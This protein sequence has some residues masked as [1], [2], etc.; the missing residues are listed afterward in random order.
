MFSSDKH[1]VCPDEFQDSQVTVDGQDIITCRCIPKEF[2]APFTHPKQI[3][4]TYENVSKGGRWCFEVV[5]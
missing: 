1:H 3:C 4:V 2:A 5:R